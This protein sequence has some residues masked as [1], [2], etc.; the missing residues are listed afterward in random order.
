[1]GYAFGLIGSKYFYAWLPHNI[2]SIEV[3]LSN[4]AT[5]FLDLISSDQNA[6]EEQIEIRRSLLKYLK[7][8]ENYYNFEKGF[9][10][11]STRNK[12]SIVSA[13]I[14]VQG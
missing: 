9:I 4:D 14:K 11:D 5:T 8:S 6:Y 1:M 3:L 2:D 13:S 7:L 10:D 12:F